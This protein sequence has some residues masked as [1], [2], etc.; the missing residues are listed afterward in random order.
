MQRRTPIR[1]F[2]GNFFGGGAGNNSNQNQQNQFQGN[3]NNYNPFET[4]R[5][6]NPYNNSPGA[7]WEHQREN[8]RGG[9]NPLP[10]E[11]RGTPGHASQWASPFFS[12][13][14]ARNFNQAHQDNQHYQ[15]QNQQQGWS[16]HDS[17]HYSQQLRN[18]QMS[19][20]QYFQQQN[21]QQYG[22]QQPQGFPFGGGGSFWSGG[23]GNM[24]NNQQHVMNSLAKF[25]QMVRGGNQ[26]QQQ[27]QSGQRWGDHQ[28][29]GGGGFGGG[30]GNNGPF[31]GGGGPGGMF[32]K[33]LE[34]C[35]QS[36]A[37]DI[38]RRMG[39]NLQNIQFE[40][41][42]DGSVKVSVEAPG[43]TPQQIEE[44]GRAVQ[45]ECPI[46]RYRKTSMKEGQKSMEW[47]KALPSSGSR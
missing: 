1:F 34:W 30:G 25:G 40:T 16:P 35:S 21:Q 13:Q 43:A 9:R 2:F 18:N 31:G 44:L 36:H 42:K 38:A 45:E 4:A 33:M 19:D 27:Q 26:Q 6:D 23:G 32:D 3:N 47:V 29:G 46:A 17:P 11:V 22:N 14:Q 37:Q 8:L 5:Q 7:W 12:D 24:M 39:I 28:G 15:Q 41:Q 20:Q 10:H